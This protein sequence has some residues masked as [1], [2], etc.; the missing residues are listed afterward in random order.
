M[1]PICVQ[2]KGVLHCSSI[3]KHYSSLAPSFKYVPKHEPPSE[4][5]VTALRNFYDHHDK[6]FVLTGKLFTNAI[7]LTAFKY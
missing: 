5:D 1:S 2:T 6:L 7:T 4:T 3:L